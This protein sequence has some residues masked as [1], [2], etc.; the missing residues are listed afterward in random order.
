MPR[1]PLESSIVERLSVRFLALALV[2][3]LAAGCTPSRFTSPF[4]V[5]I[6]Q[7]S[8]LAGSSAS[9]TATCRP[10]EV[11]VGGGFFVSPDN[12]NKGL[13]VRGTYPVDP[14]GW[15]LEVENTSTVNSDN[16]T[17]M[18]V[19]Y[20]AQRSDLALAASVKVVGL[21]VAL[22]S[23]TP[24]TF[25]DAPC[26]TPSVLTGGGYRVDGP[27]DYNDATFNAGIQESAPDLSSW[28]VEAGQWLHAAS[29]RLVQS[30]AVCTTGLPMPSPV[31]GSTTPV[32]GVLTSTDAICGPAQY[33][34][35]GGFRLN[36][37]AHGN[38]D[39]SSTAF[40][41][42]AFQ[43]VAV[44]EFVK[45]RV[46]TNTVAASSRGGIPPVMAVALCASIP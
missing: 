16:S 30:F 44:E 8:A 20:C 9:V 14:N 15:T 29:T 1:E 6:P 19:A 39:G 45:W 4:L 31:T 23:N 26:L 17:I 46:D 28:H 37:P 11:R 25:I 12:R 38:P 41:G 3:F 21:P 33:A 5:A 27:L 18:A 40:T 36:G 32:P 35:A 7:A 43:S 22:G 42:R 34:T 13:V 2:A 10:G 24:K